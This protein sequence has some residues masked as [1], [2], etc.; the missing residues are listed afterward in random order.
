M[1]FML[2]AAVCIPVIAG[3][4]TTP[5]DV[6]RRYQSER[7]ACDSGQPSEDR[8]TCLREAAAARDA[9]KGGQLDESQ[10]VYERNALARCDALPQAD[11]DIC[12]RRTRGEGVTTGS[13][14]GGGILR[15]YREII[16][17]SEIPLDGA[18][19]DST[20]SEPST[21]NAVASPP[22]GQKQD[23]K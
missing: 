1:I 16:L 4:R 14:S 8:A 11:R 7:A 12:R 10:D 17:P 2:S 15:E 22:G 5:A 19:M 20:A 23:G 9:T 13:V 18:A 6:E 21:T 3:G